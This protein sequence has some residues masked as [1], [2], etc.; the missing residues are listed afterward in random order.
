MFQ[1]LKELDTDNDDVISQDE[2]RTVTV[3]WEVIEWEPLQ[4]GCL[5]YFITSITHICRVICYMYL[6]VICVYD[7]VTT[8]S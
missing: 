6:Y 8:D 2:F 1:V 4:S 5:S 3:P 7:M